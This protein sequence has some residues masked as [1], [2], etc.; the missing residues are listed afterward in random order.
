VPNG[1]AVGEYDAFGNVTITTFNDAGEKQLVVSQKGV[2]RQASLFRLDDGYAVFGWTDDNARDPAAKLGGRLRE[3]DGQFNQIRGIAADAAGNLYVADAGNK[4]I[5]VF[6]GEGAFKSQ[7]TGIG[8]PQAIC[9]SGGATQYLYSSN[10]NDPESMDNGEIYKVQLSGQV[11]GKFGKAG[12]L[13]KEFGI[14]N[15][16]DCRTENDL[17]VGEV[18]NWRAQ[19]VTLRR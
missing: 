6:D 18:W 16:I 5:Q 7:I 11:V 9:V 3:L 1:I 14:V 4:R 12:K 19:K 13:P 8:T 17:W 2:G 15:A 10:S